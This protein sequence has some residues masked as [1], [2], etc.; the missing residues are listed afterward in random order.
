MQVFDDAGGDFGRWGQVVR[1]LKTLVPQPEKVQAEFV[2]LEQV[3]IGEDVETL[4]L[5]PLM[6]VLRM[7]T[8]DKIIKIRP[9]ERVGTQRKVDICA[10]VV[11]PE[12]PGVR[13]GT[14]LP[15]VKKE[16]VRFDPLSVEEASG[17]TQEGMDITLGEQV[18][19]NGLAHTTLEEDV[20]GNNDRRPPI[21]FE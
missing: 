18:A 2:A 1:S 6:T 4:A 8:G 5:L 17:Q 16:D 14:G 3:F 19:A 11:D 10:Q 20:V 7:I 13:I 21:F 9:F 12:L 15:L